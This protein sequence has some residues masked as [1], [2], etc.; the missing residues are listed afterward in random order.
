MDGHHAFTD[1]NIV[2]EEHKQLRKLER[3]RFHPADTV[4]PEHVAYVFEH[5][6]LFECHDSFMIGEVEC[7]TRVLM[8]SH[9]QCLAVISDKNLYVW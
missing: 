7:Y 9:A 8:E 5:T 1:Q 4:Y 3:A 6:L 2:F